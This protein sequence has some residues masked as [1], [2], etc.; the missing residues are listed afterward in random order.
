LAGV[1]R[2][3]NEHRILGILDSPLSSLY[4]GQRPKK[5]EKEVIDRKEAACWYCN[6]VTAIG[7]LALP[8]VTIYASAI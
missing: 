4:V 7:C 2:L 3:S 1:H 6:V 5:T 8:F